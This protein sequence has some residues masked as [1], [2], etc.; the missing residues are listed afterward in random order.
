LEVTDLAL[1]AFVFMNAAG[2]STTGSTLVRPDSQ[3]SKTRDDRAFP[4]LPRMD[5]VVFT[6]GKLACSTPFSESKRAES[7]AWKNEVPIIVE[8]RLI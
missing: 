8:V 7:F 4:W 5:I 1:I 6:D 3:C 2:I